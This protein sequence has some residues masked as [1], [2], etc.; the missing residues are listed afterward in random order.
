[1][2]NWL[3]NKG[4]NAYL[5]SVIETPIT[6]PDNGVL[7]FALSWLKVRGRQK[8]GYFGLTFSALQKQNALGIILNL[9]KLDL[10]ITCNHIALNKFSGKSNVV[11]INI[12]YRKKPNTIN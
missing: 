1:L 4:D 2:Q 9:L 5:P 6:T 10:L 8:Q 12:L 7:V 11:L 3:L